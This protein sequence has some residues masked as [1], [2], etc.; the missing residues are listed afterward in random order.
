MS[1]TQGQKADAMAVELAAVRVAEELGYGPGSSKGGGVI[2]I[3][4]DADNASAAI[5]HAGDE[6]PLFMA[7][8]A[9]IGEMGKRAAEMLGGERVM[10]SVQKWREKTKGRKS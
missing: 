5:A 9:A 3:V 1:V 10:S 4:V 6:Y 8:K 2:L 7:F